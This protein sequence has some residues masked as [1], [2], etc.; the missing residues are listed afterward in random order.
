[1]LEYCLGDAIRQTALCQPL[2]HFLFA[3][4]ALAADDVDEVFLEGNWSCLLAVALYLDSFAQLIERTRREQLPL[5]DD[6]DIAAQSFD[7]LQHV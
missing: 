7:D 6:R 1:M 3:R 4:A 2:Q 5:R